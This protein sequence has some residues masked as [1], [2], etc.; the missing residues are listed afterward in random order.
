[1]QT[2][3]NT[4]LKTG[5]LIRSEIEGGASSSAMS[6]AEFRALEMRCAKFRSLTMAK[7]YAYHAIKSMAVLQGDDGFFWVSTLA[8]A[9]RL[10]KAGYEWIA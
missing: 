8:V 4:N 5:N 6:F 2:Q 10:E 9:A 1:M 7:S 3:S